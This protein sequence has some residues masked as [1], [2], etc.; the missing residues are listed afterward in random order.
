MI[1]EIEEKRTVVRPVY[2]QALCPYCHEE[3]TPEEVVYMTDP[4]LYK[5]S[6]GKCNF[7]TTSS[8]KYPYLQFED[9]KGNSI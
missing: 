1:M 2:V 6:C 3:L 4:P 8:I 7:T 5:Y 9:E